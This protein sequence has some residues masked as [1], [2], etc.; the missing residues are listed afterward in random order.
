MPSPKRTSSPATK[1]LTKRRS[2]PFSMTRSRNPACW[3]S[4]WSISSRTVPGEHS[5]DDA[6]PTTGRR[7]AGM[8][9]VTGIVSPGGGVG[10]G[11]EAGLADRGLEARDGGLDGVALHPRRDRVEGLEAVPGDVDDDPLV[12]VDGAGA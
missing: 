3:A 1:T 8:R 5:T 4:S 12:G 10:S 2:A 11:D 6:P 7:G 9:T